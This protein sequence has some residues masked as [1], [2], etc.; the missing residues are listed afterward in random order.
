MIC[1]FKR[2]LW[3][4]CGGWIVAGRAVGGYDDGLAGWWKWREDGFEDTV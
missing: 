1:V 2:P 3:V 4:L